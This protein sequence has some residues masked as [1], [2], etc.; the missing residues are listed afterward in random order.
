MNFPKILLVILTCMI[1]YDLSLHLADAFG[2]SWTYAYYG[3]AIFFPVGSFT[4]GSFAYTLFWCSYWEIAF[5]IS[6]YLLRS[7]KEKKQ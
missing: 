1:G 3:P 2:I 5:L 4:W 6:L 7:M